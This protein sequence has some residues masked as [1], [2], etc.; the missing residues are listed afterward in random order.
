LQ[1]QANELTSSRDAAIDDA[2]KAEQRISQLETQLN[3]EAEKVKELQ[4]QLKQV[5]TAI[6]ELQNK[7]TL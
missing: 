4:S 1:T 7:I 6:A 3:D 5:Q 2:R